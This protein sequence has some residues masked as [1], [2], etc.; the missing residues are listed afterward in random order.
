MKLTENT[1]NVSLRTELIHTITEMGHPKE[2]AE[3][4]AKNLGSDK[5][6]IRMLGYLYHV[7]PKSAEMI[8]DEMLAIMEDRATWIK[9][10]EL[11]YYNSKYNELLNYGLDGKNRD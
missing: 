3:L 7:K 9:K 4:V 1:V 6:M 5:A 2:F 10:K 8:A 11:E